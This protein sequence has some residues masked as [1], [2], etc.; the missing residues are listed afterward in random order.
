MA[1]ACKRSAA[2]RIIAVVMPDADMDDAASALLGAAYGSAGERCMAISIAVAVGEGTAD[3]SGGEAR[4]DGRE[5]R[6]GLPANAETEM[7]PLITAEHR[8]RVCEYIESGVSEGA[9]A[10]R[11]WPYRS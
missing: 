8:A 1:S 2:P 11:R 9:C 5:V 3:A 7:G 4:T 6:V 10:G